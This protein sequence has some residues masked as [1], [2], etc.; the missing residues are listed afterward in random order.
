MLIPIIIFVVL[1]LVSGLEQLGATSCQLCMQTYKIN[2]TIC[3]DECA[4]QKTFKKCTFYQCVYDVNGNCTSRTP[5]TLTSS[6]CLGTCCGSTFSPDT[7]FTQPNFN[8]C[9][10]RDAYHDE[11]VNIGL[12]LGLILAL[13]ALLFLAALICLL[14]VMFWSQEQP[15]TASHRVATGEHLNQLEY[16]NNLNK[17]GWRNDGYILTG[18]CQICS[19][20]TSNVTAACGHCYHYSC[21]CRNVN[22]SG[23]QRC[24]LCEKPGSLK[25]A[26]IFCSAC[27]K[28]YKLI[29]PDKQKLDLVLSS[30]I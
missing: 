11:T 21:L 28:Q 17:D 13:L 26:K 22:V 20:G 29:R 2:C 27:K 4:A 12:T 25:D 1:G 23:Q 5:V 7:P 6:N 14:V 19:N 15:K 16:D 18:M 30:S 3:Y 24:P 9:I 8:L 10:E